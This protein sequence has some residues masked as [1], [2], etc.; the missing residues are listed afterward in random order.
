M[1][2][3]YSEPEM[4]LLAGCQ[5]CPINCLADRAAG[6]VG[7]CG[8]GHTARYFSA[9]V[10]YNE[11]QE[12]SPTFAIFFSGCN[13]RCPYCIV[14][15]CAW[16]A[17]YGLPFD[18]EVLAQAVRQRAKEG[19][20]TL[21]FLGG[22]PTVSLPAA[23]SLVR[24]LDGILP[25]VW[26]SNMYFSE[27]ARNALRQF[28]WGY[29]PDIRCGPDCA[30]SLAAPSDYFQVASENTVELAKGAGLV[31]V[32]HLVLPGHVECCAL[33][34][35]RWVA[36]NLPQ[37]VF[38]PIYNY[39]PPRE[40]APR[41]LSRQLRPQEMKQMERECS[42][43]G[44]RRTRALDPGLSQ[45]AT[46]NLAGEAEE[47]WIILEPDGSATFTIPSGGMVM[48]AQSLAGER[49]VSRWAREPKTWKSSSEPA[50][51]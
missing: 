31:L 38:N 43:L 29:V 23:M 13:M 15:D 8:A 7:E 48:A 25:V 44:L 35:A 28:V 11:E 26:N 14:R 51:R 24:R 41:D 39:L 12:I 10:L 1:Q 18:A 16:S 20:R 4:A 47:A 40:R 30:A 36:D 3:S 50:T 9:C 49:G 6:Q 17:D 45:L 19:V 22:E 2:Q 5:L 34:I 46:C 21:S 27:V 33:P 32:R 37:A 42:R